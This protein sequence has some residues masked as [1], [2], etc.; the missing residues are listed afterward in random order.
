[1]GHSPYLISDSYLFG[2]SYIAG[3]KCILCVLYR[4][5]A[6]RARYSFFQRTL[7]TQNSAAQTVPQEKQKSWLGAVL[8]SY[9]LLSGLTTL[10]GWFG[11][12]PRLTDWFNTGIAM[13]PNTAVV[14]L[15]T[16]VAL[17]LL[18]GRNSWGSRI[19][20]GLAI[21]IAFI[22]GATLFQH[23]SSIN[24]GIDTLLVKNPWSTRAASAPGRMGPPASIAFTLSS[25]AMIFLVWGG[26]VRRAIP[27]LAIT[28]SAIGT[29]GILG[30]AFGADALFS[31]KNLTGIAFQT[32]SVI[33]ACGLALLTQIPELEPT[34]TLSAKSAAGVLS[35]RALVLVI[36]L[37][38]VLGWLRLRGERM[39]L[40][41]TATGT[42]LLVLALIGILCWLLWWSTRVIAKHERVRLE[43]QLRLASLAAVV[44]QSDDAIITK[45]LDG[46]I[47]SWNAG[48]ERLFGYRPE[49]VIGKSISILIPPELQDEE[50]KILRRLRA[51][52]RIHH[53]ETIRRRQDGSRMDISL[54][55]SPVRDPHGRIVGASK[56]ARDVTELRKARE[57]LA[58][59]HENLEKL[60]AE[61]T[62]SLQ[63]AIGQ[64]EEFSYTVSHDLR[65]PVRAIKGYAQTLIEDHANALDFASRDY[66]GRIVRSALRMEQLIH[67]VLTYS[68]VARAQ[69]SSQLVSF[70][71]LLPD[72]ISQLPELQPSNAEILIREPLHDVLAHEP[73]LAQA[74]SNLLI[75]SAKFVAQGVHPK[76]EL[77]TELNNGL[78]RLWVTD[79]GIGIQPK[80]QSRLFSMFERVHQDPRYEGTGI[81][82][83]IVRKAAE[84]MGG[85]VGVESDGVNGSRFWIELPAAGHQ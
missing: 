10:V 20:I 62:S 48:A 53:Y 12:I 42:A 23:F 44:E 81:G 2:L 1:V 11:H 47:T 33:L 78:V 17:L 22:G 75:N 24:L 18:C 6:Q 31:I 52:E 38:I 54:A 15:C 50:P 21:L 7:V 83:A 80:L 29:L 45:D 3:A 43:N 37:P 49:E 71:K 26:H 9:V 25:I 68:R 41:D 14:S 40:F 51:G 82:L 66:L 39:N 76:I 5:T 70:K 27:G 63:Q 74:V 65:A 60:V 4:A 85:R 19:C 84:K 58:K 79:N 16:G 61:R 72:V 32:A 56:I 59:S 28:V 8:A 13:F 64:M 34:R 73:S 46:I 57:A 36:G 55:V 30:Y 77:R 67:D 69:A 35:R